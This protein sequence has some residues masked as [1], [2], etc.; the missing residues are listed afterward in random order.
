MNETDT[1]HDRHSVPTAADL[2]DIADASF[3]GRGVVICAGGVSMF[4]NAWVLVWVLRKVLR[5]SLPVEVW[6]LGRPEMSHGMKRMLED[7]GA[8]M[9]DAHTVLSRYPASIHDGWQLKAYALI[10]SPFREVLLLD[11]DN[12]PVI[13]PALLFDQPEFTKTGAVFWPDFLDVAAANPIWDLFD[14]PAEQRVSFESGQALIDKARHGDALKI[15]LYLN[16]HAERFY[17]MVYGDKDTFLVA[18]LATESDFTLVPHRPFSERYTT[19]QRDFDGE[20]LFQHR[21]GR[22]W[23]YADVTCDD[24]KFVH[25]VAC[26]EALAELRRIWN[27]RIFDPPARSLAARELESELIGRRFV[28]TSPGNDDVVLELLGGSQI[29]RGR[30]ETYQTWY[31]TEPEPGAFVLSIRDHHR[32]R[33]ELLQSDAHIWSR[34]A[35]EGEPGSATCLTPLEQR[36]EADEGDAE[37]NGGLVR[38]IVRASLAEGPWSAEIADRLEKTFATLILVE[39]EVADDLYELGSTEFPEGAER[40]GLLEIAEKLRAVNS[41]NQ[42]DRSIRTSAAALGD[43]TVYVRP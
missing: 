24:E 12:L 4:T 33:L 11:A 43:P 38:D 41:R 32:V 14:L 36:A 26:L 1:H 42:T 5:C 25:A 22:K 3:S 7:L 35:V 15:L 39:P 21:T 9:V 16:E 23:S 27:G 20:V 19:Y 29:G 40:A 28:L 17:Q 31:I 34:S 13:D 6:H 10:R 37:R 18:W 8:T 2:P 30:D